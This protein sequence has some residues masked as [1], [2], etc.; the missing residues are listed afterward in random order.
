MEISAFEALILA[1]VSFWL[2]GEIK[3]TEIRGIFFA[4]GCC[5][6]LSGIA[7]CVEALP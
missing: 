1:V 7:K 4:G 5:F 6:L 2:M 3:A